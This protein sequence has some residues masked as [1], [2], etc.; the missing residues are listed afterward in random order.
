MNWR[1]ARELNAILPRTC[2]CSGGLPGREKGKGDTRKKKNQ[3]QTAKASN[4]GKN[5]PPRS[6][7]KEDVFVDPKGAETKSARMGKKEG[8]LKKTRPSGVCLRKKVASDLS[9]KKGR[10]E[11]GKMKTL[12]IKARLLLTGAWIL[13]M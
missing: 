2:T 8:G 10:G 3:H 5:D 1:S 7:C 12:G 6:T 9:Q 11:R 13:V 4:R